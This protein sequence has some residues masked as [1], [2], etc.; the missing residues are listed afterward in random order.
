[1]YALCH[2]NLVCFLQ[3][4]RNCRNYAHTDPKIAGQEHQESSKAIAILQWTVPAALDADQEAA[5]VTCH[6]KTTAAVTNPVAAGGSEATEPRPAI[7]TS[8]NEEFILQ[9]LQQTAQKGS[10]MSHCLRTEEN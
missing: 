1:M 4:L 8:S 5:G 10:A 7:V 3:I 6:P 9:S 2:I